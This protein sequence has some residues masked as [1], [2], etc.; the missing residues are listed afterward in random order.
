MTMTDA[1]M[2]DAL[3]TGNA[4]EHSSRMPGYEHYDGA[5]W[6]RA[7]DGAAWQRCTDPARAAMLDATSTRLRQ[8]DAAADRIRTE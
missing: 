6:S 2:A 3:S 4:R 5:W 1:K 7:E 8:A